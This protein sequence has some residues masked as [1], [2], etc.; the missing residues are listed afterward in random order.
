MVFLSMSK[1]VSAGIT[2]AGTMVVNHTPLSLKLNNAIHAASRLFDSTAKPN[3]LKML[4]DNHVGVEDRC[5]QAYKVAVDISD[6]LKQ[7]VSE[8]SGGKVLRMAFVSPEEAKTGFT[9]STFSFN[10]PVPDN[11]TAADTTA[12]AQKFTDLL[13][14]GNLTVFKPCVSFGQNN[15]L[16]YVTVPATST[17]GAIKEEHKA[18]QAVGGVQL[19]RLSFPPTCDAAV[20]KKIIGDAVKAVYSV[21]AAAAAAK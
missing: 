4:C 2:T 11:A 3:Q 17:Q 20:I 15:G 6:F 21:P 18:K 14:T 1:S 13:T 5:A 16:V 9:T 7:C 12:L 8:A 19:V 10:L